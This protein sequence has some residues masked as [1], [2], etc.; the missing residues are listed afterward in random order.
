MGNR[1]AQLS[2]SENL[3]QQLLDKTREGN[4]WLMET[5]SLPLDEFNYPI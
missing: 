2:L 4:Q 1:G 5:W 3:K